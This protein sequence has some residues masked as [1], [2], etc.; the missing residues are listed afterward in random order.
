MHICKVASTIAATVS[1][2]KRFI[3]IVFNN[4]SSTFLGNPILHK[5]K[6]CHKELME[7][8]FLMNKLRFSELFTTMDKQ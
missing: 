4:L 6:A 2:K 7:P 8:I 3:C 1:R 5:K